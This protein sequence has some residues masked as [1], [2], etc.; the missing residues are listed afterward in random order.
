VLPAPASVRP[1]VPVFSKVVPAPPVTTPVW[2]AAPPVW[3]NCTR[4]LIVTA[5]AMLTAFA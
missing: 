3:L 1:P 4:P 2:V 5:F